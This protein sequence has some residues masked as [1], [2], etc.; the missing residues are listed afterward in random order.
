MISLNKSNIRS[1]KGS[2]NEKHSPL[3]VRVD[4][5]PENLLIL[6]KEGGKPFESTNFKGAL[7]QE[8]MEDFYDEDWD[9]PEVGSKQRNN[10]LYSSLQQPEDADDEGGQSSP[11]GDDEEGDGT[12]EDEEY[13]EEED[14][15]SPFRTLATTYM[16]PAERER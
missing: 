2:R 10:H 4:S 1:K 12:P 8:G 5:R 11:Y 7:Q 9:N 14:D 13:Y 16:D 15:I 6:E 3:S